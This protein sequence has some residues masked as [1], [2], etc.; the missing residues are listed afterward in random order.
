MAYR[1]KTYIA[2][3]WDNDKDVVDQLIKWN[4]SDYWGLSFNNAHDLTKARDD[5]LPCSIKS[6]LAERLDASKTFVLIIGSET[7]SRRA[8]E[9]NYC[10][11]LFNCTQNK[12]NKS[13]IEYEC[14]K[15]IRDEIKIVVIYKA[16]TVDKSK[17]LD[18][19]KYSGTHIALYNIVNGKYELN[20]QEIKSAI[21]K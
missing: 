1:T 18:S 21:E 9:C 10:K 11:I 13:Y 6:S 2:G 16:A 20:Y 3:D 5:S 12:S 4:D 8:G 19:I 17:C 15:A 7:K 14:D